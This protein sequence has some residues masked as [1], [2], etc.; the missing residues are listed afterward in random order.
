MFGTIA[1][2]ELRYQFRNPVFW[3]ATVL[4]FLL[5]FGATTVES[6]RLGSGG[7]IFTNAPT[8]IAQIMLT[9]SLFFM[10]VTTA[11]VANVV[12]RDDETGFGGII[13]STKVN[14][15]SYM[16]GRFSGAFLGAAVAFLAVPAAIWIGTWMPWVDPELIGPNRLQDYA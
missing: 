6:I 4:F 5:T 13:R 2:F 11:F 7:N 1:R 12:V 8:A 14:K 15:L 9:M 10:F 16:L 3:V